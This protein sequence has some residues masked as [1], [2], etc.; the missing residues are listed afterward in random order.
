MNER[1]CHI[2]KIG[3]GMELAAKFGE[4]SWCMCVCVQVCVCGLTYLINPLLKDLYFVMTGKVPVNF[5][6]IHVFEHSTQVAHSRNKG[7]HEVQS[8]L[9][10]MWLL[11]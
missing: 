7:L 1:H 6:I 4:T 8:L 5:V 3:F 9:L 11:D 2:G 10:K